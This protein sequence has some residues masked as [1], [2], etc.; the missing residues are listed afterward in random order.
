MPYNPNL[1]SG[2]GGVDVTSLFGRFGTQINSTPDT[3]ILGGMGLGGTA[4]VLASFNA[5]QKA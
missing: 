1:I 2:T 4:T 5:I 3:L